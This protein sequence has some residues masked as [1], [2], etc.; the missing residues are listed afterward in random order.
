MDFTS[1][2]FVYTITYYVV[3]IAILLSSFE[4]LYISTK[5]HSKGL[6]TWTISKKATFKFLDNSIIGK[7]FSRQYFNVL[8][9]AK[10]A[11]TIGMYFLTL[12]SLTWTFFI[13]TLLFISLLINYR[14]VF[15]KEGSDQMQL[16][17]LI[18]L[19]ISTNYYST[20]NIMT[21]GLIFIAAQSY[22]SYFVA[23]VS[24]IV[25]KSW[26]KGDALFC[27]INT[28]SFGNKRLAKVMYKN[29]SSFYVGWFV[30]LIELFFPITLFIPLHYL[31]ICLILM[32]IFHIANAIIMGLNIFPWAFLATYPSII[33]VNHFIHS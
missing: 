5:N 8:L 18:V 13:V 10:I 15:G 17:T 30:I 2:S 29:K 22:L 9:I 1:I 25:S 20:H 23:G 11:L 24:K 32:F 19:A 12:R 26:R 31:I 16:I 21:I 14:D 7:L 27:I 4:Y 28:S 3:S 33:F 6:I